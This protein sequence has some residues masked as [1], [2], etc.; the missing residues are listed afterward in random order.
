[1]SSHTKPRRAH[2][3]NWRRAIL[4]VDPLCAI[5]RRGTDRPTSLQTHFAER[6][7]GYDMQSP[8]LHHIDLGYLGIP[9]SIRVTVKGHYCMQILTRL[10]RIEHFEF[11]GPK[12]CLVLLIV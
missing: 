12:P 8:V 9:F 7:L 2:R 10:H 1:M 11:D 6:V 3:F 5:E 4:Q